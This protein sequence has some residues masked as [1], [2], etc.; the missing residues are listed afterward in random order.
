MSSERFSCALNS[1]LSPARGVSPWSAMSFICFSVVK[2]TICPVPSST[3][4]L[5]PRPLR[6]GFASLATVPTTR[7]CPKF[8]VGSM[9]PSCTTGTSR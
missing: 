9:L 6:N 3:L 5:I 2:T 4:K 1:I 8:I 7:I